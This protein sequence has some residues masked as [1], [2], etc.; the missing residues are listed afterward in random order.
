M[1][2]ASGPTALL[3]Y[4]A[5]STLPALI[6]ARAFQAGG[7]NFPVTR[8][9]ELLKNMQARLQQEQDTDEEV[10]DKLACWCET[11]DKSK[12]KAISDAQAL[13]A[14]LD[15]TIAKTTALSQTLHTEIDGLDKEIEAN[16]KSLAGATALRQQQS[17]SFNAEEKEML[18]S[19]SA[20]GSAI[21][22]LSKHHDSAALV[23]AKALSEVAA[24]AQ[25]SMKTHA[26]L[27]QG[28]ITPPQRR[29]IST[30]AQ[31]RQLV[32]DHAS[33]QKAA[34]Y[35]AQ[36]GQVYG[37]LKQMK[38]TFEFDLSESQK[39]ELQAQKV[40]DELK[41]AKETEISTGK[42][43]VES[44]TQ[45]LAVAETRL[46]EAKQ[47]SVDT[48]ATLDAD[49]QFLITLKD[50]CSMTDKEWKERQEMRHNELT[51][52]AQAI[53]ILT[54]D[55]ARDLFSRT[56]NPTSLFQVAQTQTPERASARQRAVA[57]LEAAAARTK[58]PQL[59][60]LAQSAQLDQFVK[61]KEA[62]DSLVEALLA[63]QQEEVAHRDFCV[64]EFNNNEL[65][66][67]AEIHTKGSL[68]TQVESL[69]SQLQGLN[70]TVEGLQA[71]VADLH[72]QQQ[73]A[74]EDRDMEVKEFNVLVKDQMDAQVMLK[75]ALN[76]LQ[77][78]YAVPTSTA[79]PS[80]FLQKRASS[81]QQPA[82]Q[83][84]STFKQ[85]GDA[86]GVL[87]LIQHLVDGAAAMEAQL[88]TSETEA[89]QAFVDFTTM[90]T[91]SVNAKEAA[92]LSTNGQIAQLEQDLTQAKS[93]F[94]G[95]V[96]QLEALSN[97]LGALH[98]SCDYTIK[99]FDLR[100]ESRSQEVDALRQAKAIL[101]GMQ[102]P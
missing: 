63:E 58:S 56:Y 19:I 68:Q 42:A 51:A 26:A 87:T 54:S 9:V 4:A 91:N 7:K 39:E 78:A 3:A 89:Q 34:P 100:Q 27:L 35:T 98:A 62:I 43:S 74:Q 14:D 5:T 8:V 44:K 81:A 86:P 57:L 88:K 25:S 2:L 38:E 46:A 47:E 55:D 21:V 80:G 67:E 40:Y 77:Q 79:A 69:E 93:D 31:D 37:I 17:A 28:T 48:Y 60:L 20:L 12:T 71:E 36:S 23:T 72:L 101:S 90:T 1:K 102:S 97:N 22:V 92:I 52:V 50:K 41:K 11:N 45:E 85:D 53:A 15:A 61:V 49:Q 64:H 75:S 18:Q 99:N 24:V 59:V 73:R 70:S 66:T 10:Y 30:L 32:E 6:Q 13:I 94:Q 83:G 76:V 33:T 95:S 29:L 82:P 96:D 16:E 65:S 84:F